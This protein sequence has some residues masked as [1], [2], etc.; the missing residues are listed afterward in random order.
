VVLE[1]CRPR[2]PVLGSAYLFYFRRILPRLGRLVSGV[3]NGAYHYLPESVMAFPER[4]QFLE[5]MRRGGLVEPRFHLLTL[6]IAALYRGEV[7]R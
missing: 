7:R 4:E 5:L 6:G 1:F 3:S 2:V